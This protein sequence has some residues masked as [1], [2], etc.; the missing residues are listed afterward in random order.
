VGGG[1]AECLGLLMLIASLFGL[2]VVVI[3]VVDVVVVDVVVFC[4]CC[5]RLFLVLLVPWVVR[6]VARHKA[7]GDADRQSSFVICLWSEKAGETQ[8][9]IDQ[10]ALGEEQRT[11]VQFSSGEGRLQREEVS[12]SVK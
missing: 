5:S 7:Q 12:R 4:C 2:F 11:P 10:G 9:S 8:R 6:A 1:R 3:V